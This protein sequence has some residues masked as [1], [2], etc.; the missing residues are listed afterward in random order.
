[1]QERRVSKIWRPI[2]RAAPGSRLV[3]LCRSVDSGYDPFLTCW[4]KWIQ[5]PKHCVGLHQILSIQWA[6]P[7]IKLVNSL[8]TNQYAQVQYCRLCNAETFRQN[9][10]FLFPEVIQTAQCAEKSFHN[11]GLRVVAWTTQQIFVATSLWPVWNTTLRY[12]T[13]GMCNLAS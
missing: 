5:F 12:S 1:M 7:S 9:I 4:R 11:F 3:H 6:I 13:Q 8:T 10:P 2:N